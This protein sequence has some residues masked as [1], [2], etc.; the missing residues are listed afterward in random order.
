MELGN[1]CPRRCIA[2]FVTSS[3]RALTIANRRRLGLVAVPA[4]GMALLCATSVAFGNVVH[5]QVDA[6]LQPHHVA[7][8]GFD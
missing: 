5:K 1:R 7:D 6:A 2:L 3:R 8:D 4:V